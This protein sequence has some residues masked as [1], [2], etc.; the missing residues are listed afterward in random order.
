[1][2]F[3]FGGEND[4]CEKFR[5]AARKL[6]HVGDDVFIAKGFLT[7]VA[8]VREGGEGEAGNGWFVDKAAV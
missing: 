4:I 6:G 1:M 2:I 5:A 7:V 8:A 3:L